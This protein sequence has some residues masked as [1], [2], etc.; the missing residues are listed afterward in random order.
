[1]TVEA[2]ITLR[3]D[4]APAIGRE[5]IRLLEAVAR[6]GSITAGAKAVGLSYKAAWDALDAMANLLGQQLLETRAGGH[7]GGGATLTPAGSR[8]IEAFHRL[9]AELTRVLRGFEPELAGIGIRPTQLVSGFLMRTSARNALRGTIKE[10]VTDKLTAEVALEVSD[11]STIYAIV[12][13]E[14]MRELGLVPGR[15]AIALIKA[16]FVIIA[17]G[18]R[19]PITSV[20]NCVPGTV[21][22]CEKSAVSAEVVLDIGGGKTLAATI[23]AHGAEA[24]GLRKGQRAY[25]LVEASHVIIAID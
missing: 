22:R 16:P 6:L 18:E 14:S 21:L 24:L 12:T 2:L 3:S 15:V 20:R 10:I 13:A 4:T 9:E 8:V 25:A 17:P 11:S 19:R 1:M 23:T 5:R 7:A